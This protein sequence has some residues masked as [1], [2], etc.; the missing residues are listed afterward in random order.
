MT[1]IPDSTPLPIE[2]WATDMHT[3]IE[4]ICEIGS[5]TLATHRKAC[6]R[7]AETADQWG[8][9]ARCDDERR[10]LHELFDAA[11][12]TVEAIESTRA[13]MHG[14]GVSADVLHE[15]MRACSEMVET[16]LPIIERS[17][18]TSRQCAL[19]LL[20]WTQRFGHVEGSDLP[21]QYRASY[22]ELTSY[23]PTFKPRL[24]AIQKELL[25]WSHDG[26]L[27]PEA[28]R[29]LSALTRYN[30]VAD[31]A[32]GFVKS[33]VDPP[34]ELVFHDTETFQDDWHKLDIAE[35]GRLATELNDCC[36]LLLYKPAEF[37]RRV[38]NIRAQ[39][40][41]GLDASL[42]V[43]HVEDVRI[44]FTVDDDPLFKQITITL[45]RVVHAN[46]LAEAC[47]LVTQ[48][49]YNHLS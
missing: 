10:A 14:E 45:L 34:F 49:L 5:L 8:L 16:G 4:Q 25:A 13:L 37:Q 17:L 19:D 18:L 31:S 32:R 47:D 26:D 1:H 21:E 28:Q 11:R 35:R 7:A 29:L 44:V 24:D 30:A 27:H 42:Y 38:E 22:A 2:A 46:Q 12:K 41:E 48:A 39:L 9:A 43:L 15:S 33:I 6:E 23:T 3:A 20:R 40:A 36:Q